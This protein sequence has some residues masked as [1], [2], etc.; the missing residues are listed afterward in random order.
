METK[1]L[2]GS[3]GGMTGKLNEETQDW[4]VEQD[5][6]QILE[7]AK[8]DRENAQY[9]RKRDL[10]YKKAFTIP[11]IVAIELLSKYDIDVH[12]PDFM[13]DQDKLKKL[14]YIIKTEYPHL[15]AY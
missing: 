5:V 9:N 11:D 10:G 13:R 7:E 2:I 12:H 1:H 6:T 14:F 4:I 8:R 15:M 3:Q